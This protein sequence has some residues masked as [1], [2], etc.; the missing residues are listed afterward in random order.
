M[1]SQRRKESRVH[2]SVPPVCGHSGG[3]STADELGSLDLVAVLLVVDGGR[4]LL[5]HLVGGAPINWVEFAGGLRIK[6]VVLVANGDFRLL[7]CNFEM[8]VTFLELI[9][10]GEMRGVAMSGN[11][12]GGHS[13]RI[14]LN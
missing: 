4:N 11:V 1:G 8:I 7:P 13:E 10:K 14:G 2:A 3:D 6:H 5:R 9:P 12:E